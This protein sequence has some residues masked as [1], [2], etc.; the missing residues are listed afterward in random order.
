MLW[1]VRHRWMA[2]ERFTFIFYW[3][4]AH[5][6]LH[7]YGDE[8]VILMTREGVA[9]GDPLLMVLYGITLVPLAE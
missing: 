1:K 7:Q 8:P 6:L 5:L 9:Q 3:Y 2:G 4:W